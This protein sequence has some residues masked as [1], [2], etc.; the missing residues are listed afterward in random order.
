MAK[1]AQPRDGEPIR[2]ALTKQGELR[3]RVRLDTGTHP[4]TGKR[5]Q[6]WSTHR[7]LTEARAY[8]DAH[9][10]DVARGVLVCLDRRNRQSFQDFGE[11]WV[12]ARERRGKIRANTAVGYRSALRRANAVFGAKPVAEVSESDV[13]AMA[14]AITDAGRTQ[15]TAAFTLFVV[16]AVFKEAMR[17]SLIG[18]NP[19]EFI[20]ASGRESK[21]REALTAAQVKTLREFLQ[22]KPLF[23]CW[24]LTLY[25]L[26]RSEVMGLR[27]SDIN[28]ATGTLA[29]TR[30]RVDVNGE[31]SAEGPPKT[32]LG[33][34]TLE[35]PADLLCELRTL[36]DEQ[37]SAFGFE[38]VRT[39]YLAVDV[40]GEPVRP[41]R[42]TD[43][44]RERCKA[45]GLPA[46]TLHAA[47]HTS[48]TA[49]RDAGVPDHIV[50]AWH[51]HDEVVMRRTY[52]FPHRD[53]MAAAGE[54]LSTAYGGSLL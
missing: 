52:S 40:L 7:T 50:A 38:H 46:V 45:A 5:R 4:K 28:L 3:Y 17:R 1:I 42:W 47:R 48:V 14:R 41:E 26:R 44:W 51:G 8:V 53:K 49:M 35:L 29:I 21:A 19:A 34:R 11:A 23:P 16:R 25:G 39:G 30:A 22:D 43:L 10:T 33:A 9:R 2:L 31:R 18:R 32:R 12:S 36:R 6:A 13:E 37:G 54:A 24:L 27:W 15:R 20:E